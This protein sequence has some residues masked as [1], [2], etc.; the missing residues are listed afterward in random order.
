MK[1]LAITLCSV[2][3]LG[4]GIAHAQDTI[5]E[6]V[7]EAG[8]GLPGSYNSQTTDSLVKNAPGPS[9]EMPD[10]DA[11]P[12]AYNSKTPGSIVRE[13][14]AEEVIEERGN[15][16]VGFIE[17]D[18]PEVPDTDEGELLNR[19]FNSQDPDAMVNEPISEE[20]AEERAIN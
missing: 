19:G 4:F 3:T 14:I 10:V 17:D 7:T 20:I 8:A 2:A 18:I 6:E 11:D 15:E 16:R 5:S 13:G 1:K 12:R 9:D